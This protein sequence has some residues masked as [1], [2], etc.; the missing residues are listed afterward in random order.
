MND[1][2]EKLFYDLLEDWEDNLKTVLNDRS[3]QSEKKDDEELKT[4][5]NQYLQRFE[6]LMKD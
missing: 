2:F 5:K 1:S 6:K 3:A 4:L